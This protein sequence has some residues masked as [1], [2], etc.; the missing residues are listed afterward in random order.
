MSKVRRALPGQQNDPKHPSG[1]PSAPVSG[2]APQSFVEAVRDAATA[3]VAA[4]SIDVERGAEKVREAVSLGEDIL[5]EEALGY[6]REEERLDKVGL[7]KGGVEIDEL[8]GEALEGG[9][10]AER[11][12]GIG[13]RGVWSKG[14]WRAASGRLERGGSGDVK[15]GLENGITE[16]STTREGEMCG[17]DGGKG[18]QELTTE[19]AVIPT[20][21]LEEGEQ[22]QQMPMVS[23]NIGDSRVENKETIRSEYAMV[24]AGVL[25]PAGGNGTDEAENPS[26]CVGGSVVE[27]LAEEQAVSPR[28]EDGRGFEL[29]KGDGGEGQQGCEED[30]EWVVKMQEL[31]PRY[32][33][34]PDQTWLW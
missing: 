25:K 21:S 27:A 1:V 8:W 14:S 12:R 22:R 19:E 31:H 30:R 9:N 18:E 24:E 11:L 33:F 17:L 34:C 2:T 5:W 16:R 10:V 6:P 32:P 3:A 26:P 4:A 20:G 15:S 7:V 13:S 23:G 29:D 28:E